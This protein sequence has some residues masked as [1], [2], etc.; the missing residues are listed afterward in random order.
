MN[1]FIKALFAIVFLA[2]LA[3]CLKDT[4]YDDNITGN[5]LSAVP[6]IIELATLV[7]P[8]YH[9]QALSYDFKDEDITVTVVTVR[10]AAADPAAEDITVTIDTS[11]T[12]AL[13]TAYNNAKGQNVVKMPDAIVTYVGGLTVVIPKGARSA[14]LEIITN[15]SEFDP[16]ST[17][18]FGFTIGSIDK[19][20]YVV[21]GNFGEYVTTIGAKNKYDGVYEVTGTMVDVL[22]ATFVAL[23]SWEAELVTAGANSVT[24]YDQVYFGA[25]FHPFLV[26]TSNSVSGYGSFGMVVTFDPVTDKVLSLVSP[27]VPAGNTRYG[28]LDATF[29]SYFDPVT[30]DVTIKYYMYQPSLVPVGPRVTFVEK[31]TYQGPR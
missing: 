1:K 25:P 2:G 23:P 7:N 11:H 6:K 18:G 14:N 22:N 26:T 27:Y 28:E 30:K 20:G 19:A 31:W 10:L 24:V 12:D 16:S 8:P 15:T 21:S 3:S 29:D 4:N 5:N 17:Y 9:D 13:L